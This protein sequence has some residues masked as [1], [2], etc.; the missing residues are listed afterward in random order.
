MRRWV[1]GKN[2]NH[3]FSK[4]VSLYFKTVL[5]QYQGKVEKVEPAATQMLQI[6][7]EHG[8]SAWEAAATVMKGWARAEQDCFEEGIAIIRKG[9][10]AWERDKG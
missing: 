3:P 2:T 6:C 4:A 10:A 7:Q 8:F 1:I 5:Y 9:I